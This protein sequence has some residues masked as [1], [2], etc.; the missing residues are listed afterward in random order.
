ML[1]MLA[2]AY[3]KSGDNANAVSAY[4]AYTKLPEVK[5]PEA[6][7]RKAQLEESVNPA[8]GGENVRG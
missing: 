1:R 5:D 7:Y 8:G 2:D 4:A 3:D 6:S